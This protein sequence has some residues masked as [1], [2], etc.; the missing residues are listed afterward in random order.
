M[1]TWETI[2]GVDFSGAEK[3]SY[4]VELANKR[5]L[6]A[7]RG[8]TVKETSYV[9]QAK[10]EQIRLAEDYADRIKEIETEKIVDIRKSE[11]KKLEL[12]RKT[13]D[14]SKNA[15]VAGIDSQELA[16]DGLIES[17]KDN[18]ETGRVR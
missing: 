1:A 12:V 16:E 9:R 8:R 3:W 10:I 7:V 15:V 13:A 2:K 4:Q 17:L 11:A 18:D 5:L 14:A 6:D